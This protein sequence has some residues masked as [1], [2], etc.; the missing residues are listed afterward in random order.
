MQD[1]RWIGCNSQG[2]SR[3]RDKIGSGLGK[4]MMCKV[5]YVVLHRVGSA[6]SVRRIYFNL[7][8]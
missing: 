6:S 3:T 2:E 5:C 4:L 1:A 8:V 7:P